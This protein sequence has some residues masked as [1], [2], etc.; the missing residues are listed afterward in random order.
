MHSGKFQNVSFQDLTPKN[1]LRETELNPDFTFRC[2]TL[3][4]KATLFDKL[5]FGKF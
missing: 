3:K 2:I 4:S 1:P 5:S